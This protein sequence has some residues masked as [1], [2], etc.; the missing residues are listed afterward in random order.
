MTSDQKQIANKSSNSEA[1]IPQQWDVAAAAVS[2][3]VAVALLN[4]QRNPMGGKNDTYVSCLERV[5]LH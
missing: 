4:L 3:P 5:V 1:H 2:D